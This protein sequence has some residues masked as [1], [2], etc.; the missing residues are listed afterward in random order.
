MREALKRC[1]MVQKTDGTTVII[2]ADYGT[3]ALARGL[4]VRNDGRNIPDMHEK[5]GWY[6]IVVPVKVVVINMMLEYNI[7][8]ELCF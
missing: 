1:R 2:A 5:Q 7:P 3:A 8:I 6:I 4:F